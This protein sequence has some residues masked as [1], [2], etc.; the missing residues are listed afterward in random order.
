MTACSTFWL[1]NPAKSAET[2]SD[3]VSAA[4]ESMSSAAMQIAR[5]SSNAR[6]VA[7]LTAQITAAAVPT[8]A[9]LLVSQTKR[10][11]LTGLT[12]SNLAFVPTVEQPVLK[13]KS[14]AGTVPCNA[15]YAAGCFLT[16]SSI[17]ATSAVNASVRSMQKMSM[18]AS[19]QNA[20]SRRASAT[21]GIPPTARGCASPTLKRQIVAGVC[22]VIPSWFCALRTK[23][24]SFVPATRLLAHSAAARFAKGTRYEVGRTSRYAATMLDLASSA[25]AR[26]HE[27]TGGTHS[28]PAR[29]VEGWCVAIMPDSAPFVS[30]ARSAKHTN[31]A[32]PLA[33]HAAE[34]HAPRQDV[35]LSLLSANCA[36]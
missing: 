23:P 36:G 34:F 22:L 13:S 6:Y 7:I 24:N 17:P 19:V 21:A 11:V 18:A 15:S 32:N 5:R 20:A 9:K 4:R 12:R 3:L 26:P 29:F 16:H 31:P 2:P 10:N 33:L 1:Q 27:F 35:A 30:K 25:I 28:G 14:F 8:A